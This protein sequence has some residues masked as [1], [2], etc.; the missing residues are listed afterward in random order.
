MISASFVFI[1]FLS[2]YTFFQ[3][4]FLGCNWLIV[5]IG[6]CC[7]TFDIA[8]AC[9]IIINGFVL[10]NT[11]WFWLPLLNMLPPNPPDPWL[12]KV[13]G[14]ND[15][16]LPENCLPS[17]WVICWKLLFCCP[18]HGT[19]ENISKSCR[20]WNELNSWGFKEANWAAEKDGYWGGFDWLFPVKGLIFGLEFCCEFIPKI[21]LS[22]LNPV[23][24]GLFWFCLKI[25][26]YIWFFWRSKMFLGSVSIFFSSVFV[27][28]FSSVFVSFFSSVFVSFFSSVFVS[29]FSSTFGWFW[30]VGTSL[31]IWKLKVGK[32]EED[33]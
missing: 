19:L 3:I 5:T 9:C 26:F 8:F 1:P 13:S 2:N 14:P 21:L 24:G 29:F 11:G 32:E 31:S 20:S 22:W 7:S 12:L 17:C 30:V 28:F 4:H 33:D 25:F 16:K 15:S 6:C 23:F 18:E 27:S 10:E